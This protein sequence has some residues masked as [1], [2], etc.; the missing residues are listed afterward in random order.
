MTES[1][2]DGKNILAVDDEPDVLS[3]LEEEIINACPNCKV[4]KAM[5]YDTAAKLIKTNPYDI[6]I[7]DIMGSVASISWTSL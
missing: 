2:L 4:D 7:L 5:S 6:V 1:I 3:M